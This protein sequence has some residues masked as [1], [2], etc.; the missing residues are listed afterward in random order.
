MPD[1]KDNAKASGDTHPPEAEDTSRQRPQG[2]PGTEGARGKDATLGRE[3]ENE[4]RAGKGEN[5]AGF[6]K[7]KDGEAG[8]NS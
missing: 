1:P 5:Q 4:A 8:R 7:E 6:L 3:L 2:Q